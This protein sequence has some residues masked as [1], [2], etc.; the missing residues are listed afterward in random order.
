MI[1]PCPHPC[2]GPG[3]VT[4]HTRCFMATPE[5]QF[6]LPMHLPRRQCPASFRTRCPLLS[7]S[8]RQDMAAPQTAPSHLHPLGVTRT[9]TK[10]RAGHPPFFMFGKDLLTAP[11]NPVILI[12][13]WNFEQ[14][15]QLLL[16]LNTYKEGN[17]IS[18]QSSFYQAKQAIFSFSFYQKKLF[19]FSVKTGKFPVSIIASSVPIYSKFT[20]QEAEKGLTIASCRGNSLSLQEVLSSSLSRAVFAFFFIVTAWHPELS[21][22]LFIPIQAF[23]SFAIAK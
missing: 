17:C 5:P 14:L 22:D 9:E 20:S 15:S 12:P 18:S 7:Q 11:L 16:I 23:S 21:C 2:S 1:L 3:M 6:H 10:G 4:M 8:I 19:I 13:T